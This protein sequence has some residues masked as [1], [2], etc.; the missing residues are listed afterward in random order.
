MMNEQR[1]NGPIA[2]LLP[3]FLVVLKKILEANA[4]PHLTLLSMVARIFLWKEYAL[5]LWCIPS[6]KQCKSSPV[7]FSLREKTEHTFTTC[8][9]S[10]CSFNKYTTHSHYGNVSEFMK[11]PVNVFS[12]SR[13]KPLQTDFSPQSLSGK[14][15]SQVLS[16]ISLPRRRSSVELTPLT[17]TQ[18]I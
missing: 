1:P 11:F 7:I 2:N 14:I 15:C 18:I 10:S 3:N 16:N 5:L 17:G 4:I 6:N 12:T 8:S 9:M 13:W